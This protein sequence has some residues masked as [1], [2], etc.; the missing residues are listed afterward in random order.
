MTPNLKFLS[1]INYSGMH[2]KSDNCES[3]KKLKKIQQVIS[4]ATKTGQFYP[5]NLTLTVATLLKENYITQG[6]GGWGDKRD[7]QHCIN[8]TIGGREPSYRFPSKRKHWSIDRGLQ[9]FYSL[10]G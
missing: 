5:K 8:M 2:H 1:L 6:N 3:N 9:F 10:F 4:A 7:H